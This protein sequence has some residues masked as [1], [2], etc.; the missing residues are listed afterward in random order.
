MWEIK[1]I[2]AEIRVDERIKNA[3]VFAD[4]LLTLP[5]HEHVNLKH[6]GRI[7]EILSEGC[8]DQ[9]SCLEKQQSPR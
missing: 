9:S 2:P 8:S 6:A 4:R 5:V 3:P 1:N 7:C